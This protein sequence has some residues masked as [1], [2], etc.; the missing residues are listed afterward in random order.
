MSLRSH[1]PS[2]AV[3]CIAKF[4]NLSTLARRSRLGALVARQQCCRSRNV[5][6][7]ACC[8]HAKTPDQ[9]TGQPLL[10][11][12]RM[13][14]FALSSCFS[15]MGSRFALLRLTSIAQPRSAAHTHRGSGS[16]GSNRAHVLVFD[17]ST[18]PTHI[19]SALVRLGSATR[20]DIQTNGAISERCK[21]TPPSH[22]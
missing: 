2:C 5:I 11:L 6:V 1:A 21:H 18:V 4:G 17:T 22:R 15:R 16:R 8:V 12:Q 3:F 13:L 19:T 20:Q 14:L 9:P 10:R 7:P